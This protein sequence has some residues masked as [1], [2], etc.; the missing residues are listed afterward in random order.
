MARAA[1]KQEQVEF[2]PGLAAEPDSKLQSSCTEF[3]LHRIETFVKH[4][5]FRQACIFAAQPGNLLW[6]CNHQYVH[7]CQ[8]PLVDGPIPFSPLCQY[9]SVSTPVSGEYSGSAGM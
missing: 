5:G 3:G 4:I 2:E 6:V 1:E 9:L 8:S 7:V